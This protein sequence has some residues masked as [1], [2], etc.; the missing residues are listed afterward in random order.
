MKSY[1]G[2]KRD[3]RID[4]YDLQLGLDISKMARSYIERRNSFVWYD[5]CCGDL[6]AGDNLM[7]QLSDISEKIKVR[8]IDINPRREGIIHMNASDFAVPEDADLVTCLQGINYIERY[9]PAKDSGANAVKKWYNSMR[10][11]GILAFDTAVNFIKLGGKDISDYL[12]EKLGDYVNIFPT[13]ERK[14]PHNS[15]KIFCSKNK[16]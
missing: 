6:K 4:D 12:K 7:E 16:I 11:G 9:V 2:M 15:I 3:R 8:G 1:V 5:V 14:Y 10:D 13:P